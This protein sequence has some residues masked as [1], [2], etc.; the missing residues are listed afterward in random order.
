MS[1]RSLP[2]IIGERS[3]DSRKLLQYTVRN[4]EGVDIPLS[5]LIRETQG[6]DFKR[7]YSGNGGDYYP[8]KITADDRTVESIVDFTERFVKATRVIRHRLRAI[9]IPAGR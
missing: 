8:V 9:I 3:M 1:A 2:V 7:L 5:Y 6:E 4:D